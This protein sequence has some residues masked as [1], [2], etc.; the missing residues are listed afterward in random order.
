MLVKLFDWL[1]GLEPQPATQIVRVYEQY[2]NIETKTIDIL[3]QRAQEVDMRAKIDRL[4]I[5]LKKHSAVSHSG[6]LYLLL[7]SYACWMQDMDAFS[8]FEKT[9]DIPILKQQS[10][11][12]REIDG[13]V[14]FDED[15]KMKW[16]EAKDG[17]ETTMTLIA[18]NE[19]V[20]H[21]L[22][23]AIECAMG[24]LVHLVE[25]Y[26]D[27]SLA[28]SYSAEVKGVVRHWKLWK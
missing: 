2:Q 21:K 22:N 25:W 23:T 13:Q 20:L 5:T 7:E 28:G 17:K 14:L 3:D 9:V 8:G 10:T 4:M 19:M 1:D 27:L 24:D 16:D 6:C 15:M 18:V 26:D 12:T 11:T